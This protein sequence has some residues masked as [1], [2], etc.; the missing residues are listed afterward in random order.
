MSQLQN[1]DMNC[2]LLV[3]NYIFCAVEGLISDHVAWQQR[4]WG[5]ILPNSWANCTG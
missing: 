5:P 4:I 1:S 2:F 3:Q